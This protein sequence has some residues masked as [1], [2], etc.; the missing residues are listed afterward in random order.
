MRRK[1]VGYSLNTTHER[2]GSKARG[3]ER[4]LGITIE[5]VVYLEAAIRD[6][7][8]TTP[9]GAVRVRPPFG[10]H[11]EV[12][13]VVP[14]IGDKRGR[15]SEAITVWEFAYEGDAPRMTNAYLKP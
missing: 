8:L 4:I 13:V 3:F 5:N 11:C 12:R 2:G 15:A 6:G 14:G 10:I 1:L 7:I 9:V